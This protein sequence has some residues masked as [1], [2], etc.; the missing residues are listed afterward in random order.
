M[1]TRDRAKRMKV[2]PDLAGDLVEGLEA[3]LAESEEVAVFNPDAA[4]TTN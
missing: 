1:T 2:F 3:C 4:L